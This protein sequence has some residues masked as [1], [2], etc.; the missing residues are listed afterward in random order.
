[1]MGRGIEPTG[2]ERS[3]AM[4][5]GGV[6]RHKHVFTDDVDHN[7]VCSNKYF[8]SSQCISYVVGE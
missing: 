1:M 3:Q 4:M 8:Y 6:Y 7:F 2:A 5:Y